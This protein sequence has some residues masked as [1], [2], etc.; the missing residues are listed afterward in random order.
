MFTDNG[1]LKCSQ[2][3]NGYISVFNAAPPGP[4]D[5]GYSALLSIL[6]S[7]FFQF[8]ESL[9]DIMYHR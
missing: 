9:N 1:F 8:S 4:E 5:L 3:H 7:V 2:A 6:V